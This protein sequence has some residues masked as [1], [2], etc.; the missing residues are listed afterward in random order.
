MGPLQVEDLVR[1]LVTAGSEALST[2]AVDGYVERL[3][4]YARSVAHFPAAVKEFEWRNGWFQGLS[5]AAL[6]AG[7]PDPCPIHSLWLKELDL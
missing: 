3:C 4:A 2:C 7:Q 5:Q 6:V 1:E